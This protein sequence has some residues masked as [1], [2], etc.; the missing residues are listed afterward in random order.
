MNERLE[1]LDSNSNQFEDIQNKLNEVIE[2]KQQ[3]EEN[4]T[5]LTQ[6]ID[7]LKTKFESNSVLLTEKDE[8]VTQL[9]SDIEQAEIHKT[10][11]IDNSNTL[12]KRIGELEANLTNFDQMHS[13]L[14]ENLEEKKENDEKL[15]SLSKEVDELSNK[16]RWYEET[17]KE[18]DDTINELLLKLN[19]FETS[20][21]ETES[22]SN[23]HDDKFENLEVEL[24]GLRDTKIQLE[25][26]LAEQSQKL[27]EY[28]TRLEN[29]TDTEGPSDEVVAQYEQRTSLLEEELKNLKESSGDINSVVEEKNAIIEEQGRRLSQVKLEK[30]DKDIEFIKVKE[31]LEDF[32]NEIEKLNGS[33]NNYMLEANRSLDELEKLNNNVNTMKNELGQKTAREE[34]LSNTVEAQLEKIADLQILI[35]DLKQER[36]SKEF[37]PKEANTEADE[38]IEFGQSNE[39]VK[40]EEKLDVN[41][42]FESGEMDFSVDSFGANDESFQAPAEEHSIFEKASENEE[43]IAGEEIVFNDTP[44]QE[45]NL[46]FGQD[47]QEYVNDTNMPKSDIFAHLLY[48]DVSVVSVS[49]ARATMSIASEF[50]DYLNTLIEGNNT[51]IVIDL[52]ECEFVDSTVLGVLVSS[53]KKSMSNDGDVRIVWGDNTESSMFYITRMDKVFKLFDNLQDAVQSYLD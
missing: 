41:M 24:T 36:Y 5:L 44:V 53:L 11:I 10:E 17:I 19:D 29:Q 43:E 14:N 50:K 16:T 13:S 48:G 7:E 39:D 37:E 27:E 28:S 20:K 46:E 9:Q 26:L 31:Q 51:K 4:I 45:E 2:E 34:E 40:P 49:I 3:K 32:K 25:N 35:E 30:T 6:E 33:K 12:S 15:E 22:R 38:A 21:E 8:V 47:P 18:K 42:N 52:S 23:L 1:E